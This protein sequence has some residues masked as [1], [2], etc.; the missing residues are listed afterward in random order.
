M[1]ITISSTTLQLKEVARWVNL[2]WE[3]V[4]W[5]LKGKETV[6]EDN[7][8]TTM[9]TKGMKTLY[10]CWDSANLLFM[11]IRGIQEL[12]KDSVG[13][14]SNLKEKATADQH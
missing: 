7:K 12:C 4:Y 9:Q 10:Y 3:S 8:Q 14:D 13:M 1:D 5:L 2:L 6:G 11:N